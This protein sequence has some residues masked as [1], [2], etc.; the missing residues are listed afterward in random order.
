MSVCSCNSYLK[1]H[2][3]GVCAL[4]KNKAQPLQVT[5]QILI[6]WQPVRKSWIQI[7]CQALLFD[8]WL[9]MAAALNQRSLGPNLSPARGVC[10]N[11]VATVTKHSKATPLHGLQMLIH[12]ANFLFLF[13]FFHFYSWKFL[14][15]CSVREFVLFLCS[16]KHEKDEWAGTFAAVCLSLCLSLRVWKL[17]ARPGLALPTA[18]LSTSHSLQLHFVST[19]CSVLNLN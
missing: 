13:F 10:Q 9:P 2:L 19:S 8:N 15:S 6:L 4:S 14:C 17:L 3:H 5:M 7:L 1:W 11:C 16:L 18:I 12:R